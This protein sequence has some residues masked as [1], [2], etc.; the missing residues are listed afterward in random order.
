M[1]AASVLIAQALG[2]RRRDGP[3]NDALEDRR[4]QGRREPARR[5]SW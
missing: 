1:A 5:C 4:N 3:K 2:Q